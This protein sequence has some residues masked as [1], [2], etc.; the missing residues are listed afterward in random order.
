[1]R[2]TARKKTAMLVI[3]PA[4]AG[5][6]RVEKG[7]GGGVVL[8]LLF[9]GVGEAWRMLLGACVGM[10]A[11]CVS[12]EVEGE[13][14]ARVGLLCHVADSGVSN[15]DAGCCGGGRNV[16]VVEAAATIQLCR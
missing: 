5:V 14:E 9:W 16:D 8:A 15:G 11:G 4:C 13:R 2:K 6:L 10:T 3:M 7:L 12:V 1:M